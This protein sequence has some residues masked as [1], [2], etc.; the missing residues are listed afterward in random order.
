LK[1]PPKMLA[2][3]NNVPERFY[4]NVFTCILECE[5]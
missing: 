1:F 5:S 4:L 3:T 2:F